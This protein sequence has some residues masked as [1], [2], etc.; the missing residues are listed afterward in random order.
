MRFEVKTGTA[1]SVKTTCLLV[2]VY[3]SGP[4]AASARAVNAA[5][6]GLIADLID[7]G[8]MRGK[9]GDTL[10]AAPGDGIAA[11]R[12]MLVGCG[13]KDKF[14]RGQYRKALQ[15]ACAALARTRHADAVS[16][17]HLEAVKG[18]NL[19]RRACIAAEVW[20]NAG[21]R[22]TATKS[23]QNDNGPAIE[24]LGLLAA[25][26]K[27]ADIRKGLRQGDAIG[28]GMRTA[29]EL[30]NLP[31][32]VCTPSYLVA[33]ARKIAR[34][35]P[36][37]T[38]DVL[39][40]ADM[41]KLGMGALL[42][43]TAGS[44]QPAKLIVMKYTGGAKSKAPVAL[45]GKGITFDSGGISLKPG[46]AMDEM[47]FD[48]C[49]AAAVLGC[50]TALTALKPSLNVIGIVPTCENLPSGA[51]TKPGDIV[52]S[53]AGKT[54]EVLNTDAEG[55]LILCDALTY[56]QKFKPRAIVDIATL[57]GA[58]L[59]ALGRHRS[60]LLSNSDQL[61]NALHRAGEAADD[62]V[63]RLPLG[64]EY[65]ELL[66][67]NFADLANVGGRDAGTITA[68][69]FLAEFVTGCDWAHLDIA[70]TAWLTGARKG[71]TGRPVPLLIE[72]LTGHA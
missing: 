36:N 69:C 46:P 42:S 63:W 16:C 31:G 50:M 23:D 45:V 61:A 7:G 56:V 58:C 29:R 6:G 14:D 54:I 20:H 26:G 67:S 15:S 21:Y 4:L 13:D 40:E 44:E 30:G 24:S 64:A 49:G 68:G 35:N 66:K 65:T 59:V 53:M 52:T 71:A 32:N 28:L 27:S 60:G 12:I 11:K 2:P 57:T 9:V 10:L 19:A 48:M 38:V 5:T 41:K 43:V 1:T 51:A 47:K 25:K 70:G 34:G 17:L 8:D 3:S 33:E 37:L 62:P 22:Y 55:R 18:A 39:G 72:Y